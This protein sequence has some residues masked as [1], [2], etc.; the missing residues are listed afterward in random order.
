MGVS[1]PGADAAAS[2]RA[3]DLLRETTSGNRANREKAT[4]S[5]GGGCEWELV[6][7]NAARQVWVHGVRDV[8]K[9]RVIKD[10]CGA[11][12]PRYPAWCHRSGRMSTCGTCPWARVQS[13]L[14]AIR[15]LCAEATHGAWYS[16]WEHPLPASREVRERQLAA[17]Q[18]L[19]RSVRPSP[20]TFCFC[21]HP[22]IL[23]RV[24]K[25]APACQP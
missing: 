11:S 9:G 10:Q 5:C 19:R 1:A 17:G 20:F 2:P 25:I 14:I 8:G 7:Q 4:S 22:Q 16:G 6:R 21:M 24:K 3:V 12:A 23:T 15:M 13:E 18:R